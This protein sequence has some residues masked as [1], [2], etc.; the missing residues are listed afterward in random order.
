MRQDTAIPGERGGRSLQGLQVLRAVAALG[1][2]FHHLPIF[3]EGKLGLTGV[4]PPLLLG[5]AGVDLFFV[6]SGFIMVYSSEPLFGRP[7]APRVFLLRRLSRIVPLYWAATSFL[8]GYLLLVGVAFVRVN[9]PWDVILTSYAFIPFPR[10]DGLMMP[11]LNVGWTLNYEM[12]FYLVFAAA[13]L[14]PRAW[15]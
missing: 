12:F 6:I 4:V 5:A 1:V 14:L 13:I 15:R 9:L 2:V 8:L 11:V 3:L 10:R 7:H